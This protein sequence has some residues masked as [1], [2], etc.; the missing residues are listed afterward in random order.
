MVKLVA[1]A[2]LFSPFYS[3]TEQSFQ[4]VVCRAIIIYYDCKISWDV[5]LYLFTTKMNVI[6]LLYIHIMYTHILS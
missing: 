3:R 4:L 5:L 2:F 6:I 1:F